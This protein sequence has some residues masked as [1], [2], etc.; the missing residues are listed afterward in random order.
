MEKKTGRSITN[1]WAGLEH[2]VRKPNPPTIVPGTYRFLRFTSGCPGR[3]Q[4]DAFWFGFPGKSHTLFDFNTIGKISDRFHFKW[5][6]ANSGKNVFDVLL[7][8]TYV[9][10]LRI[11]RNTIERD[12]TSR[13]IRKSKNNRKNRQISLVQRIQIVYIV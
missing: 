8:G 13:K 1:C 6:F 12:T 2:A 11:A 5:L 7:V 9:R 10:V 4:R 3:F